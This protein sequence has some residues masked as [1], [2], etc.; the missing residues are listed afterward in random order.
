MRDRIL[1][2]LGLLLALG[3]PVFTI[4]QK[5]NLL[6]KGRTVL[7]ELAPRDPRSLM[8]G[9]YMDLD[10]GLSRRLR[11]LKELP[12]NG[13]AV[14]KNDEKGVAVFQR[15]H[16]GESLGPGEFLLR[17]RNRGFRTRIG[18]ESF[19]FQEGQAGRF[20][21]AR[22]GELRVDDRGGVLLSGLRDNDL[23][24]LGDPRR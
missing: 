3:G 24:P 22:Y 21:L 19:F 9:D 14:L 12:K 6:R 16:A 4:L 23:K 15:L 20:Q 18:A 17:F 8:Q 10:Y 2:G 5:E 11:E 1:F 7:L 13:Y